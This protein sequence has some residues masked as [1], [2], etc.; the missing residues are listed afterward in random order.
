MSHPT[1]SL[2]DFIALHPA[3]DACIVL[4][5]YKRSRY[6]WFWMG[7][8]RRVAHRLSYETFHGVIPEGMDVCHHC[9]NGHCSNPRHLFLGTHE[10]NMRD[11]FLKGRRKARVGTS[12]HCPSGHPRAEFGRYKTRKTGR[13]ELYCSECHRLSSRK[14]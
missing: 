12:T 2:S 9:D 5:Q 13:K 10:D 4:N 3:T 7:G 1:N 11:A 6:A 8:V 14:P